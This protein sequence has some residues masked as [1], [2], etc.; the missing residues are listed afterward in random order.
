MNADALT[1]ELCVQHDNAVHTY[2]ATFRGL[3]V[4]MLKC[5]ATDGTAVR[6]G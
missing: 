3:G 2:V 6:F 1:L 4:T 5:M